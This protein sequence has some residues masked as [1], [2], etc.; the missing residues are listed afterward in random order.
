MLSLSELLDR[1]RPAGSP[2]AS[3]DVGGAIVGGPPAELAAIIEEL[4]EYESEAAALVGAAR[5]DAARLRAEA[6]GRIRE[7]RA[8]VPEACATAEAEAATHQRQEFESSISEVQSEADREIER[9]RAAAPA[10]IGRIVAEVVAGVRASAHA[11]SGGTGERS[12]S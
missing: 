11:S 9:L 3:S 6:N 8:T 5:A 12:S 10:R 1:F 7:I 2:G 4:R